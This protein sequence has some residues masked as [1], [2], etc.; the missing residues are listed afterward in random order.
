[1]ST[2]N[3][4]EQPADD[5]ADDFKHAFDMPEHRGEVRAQTVRAFPL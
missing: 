3:P 2:I 5:L 4:V 1:M